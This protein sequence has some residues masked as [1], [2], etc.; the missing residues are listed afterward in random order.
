M[1]IDKLD[2]DTNEILESSDNLDYWKSQGF[3]IGRIIKCCKG[4]YSNHKLFNWQFSDSPKS[5]IKKEYDIKIKYLDFK[6]TNIYIK[7]DKE[8]NTFINFKCKNDEDF[9][10]LID[11]VKLDCKCKWV[12]A[13]KH[14]VIA[15][16]RV[17]KFRKL[18]REYFESKEPVNDGK[19][20]WELYGGREIAALTGG[21]VYLTEG[22]WVDQDGN[23]FDEKD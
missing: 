9:K 22:V 21:M 12:P 17:N 15:N 3:N 23:F 8:S 10:A 2:L 13:E 5:I 7:T 20:L 6:D 18:C 14:W 1:K 16:N 19:M 11:I 4:E